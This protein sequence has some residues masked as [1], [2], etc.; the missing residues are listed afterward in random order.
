[1][2]Q[3]MTLN[4]KQL[5]VVLAHTATRIDYISSTAAR[6]TLALAVR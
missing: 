5:K 3:A 6:I 1:M 2:K 4:D